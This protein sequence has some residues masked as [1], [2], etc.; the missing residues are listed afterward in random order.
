M[1]PSDNLR[2]QYRPATEPTHYSAF[3]EFVFGSVL[4]VLM[5]VTL[6]MGAG[7]ADGVGSFLKA[8]V[9]GLFFGVPL[10]AFVLFVAATVGW[11]LWRVSVA[12]ALPL[13][14]SVVLVSLVGAL[15][16]AV[17]VSLVGLLGAPSEYERL[18]LILWMTGRVAILSVPVGL[19]FA[20]RTYG[21][22]R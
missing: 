15:A 21:R 6:W 12:T 5:L 13:W 14:V 17:A 4:L 7:T 19:F 8:V 1:G 2:G 3:F 18:V 11:G 22:L 16:L 10:G 20:W 9:L